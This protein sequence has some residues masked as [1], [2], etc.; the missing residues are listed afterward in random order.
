[1]KE[2]LAVQP[3]TPVSCAVLS[4]PVPIRRSL[5]VNLLAVLVLLAVA[6]VAAMWL[7]ARRTARQLSGAVI[8]QALDRAELELQ[9]FF[10]PVER[11]LVTLRDWAERGV[12]DLRDTDSAERLLTGPLLQV[13]WTTALILAD[14]EGRHLILQFI[15]EHWS[16]IQRGPT[17]GGSAVRALEW[18]DAAP[19]RVPAEVP[20]RDLRVRPWYEAASRKPQAIVWTG[21]YI[22][23]LGPVGLTASTTW[24]GVESGGVVGID[25]TLREVSRFTTS[26]RILDQGVVFVLTEDERAVGLPRNPER[27]RSDGDIESAL[28]KRPEGLGPAAREVAG[29]LLAPTIE[30]DVPYRITSDLGPLWAQVRPFELAGSPLTIG[31]AVPESDILGELQKLRLAVLA[32]LVAV[33]AG[34]AWR[35]RVM[36][37]SFSSPIEQLVGQSARMAT[38]DLEPGEAVSSHIAEV[39]EL[40]A[41]HDKMRTGLKTLLKLEDDLRIAREIQQKTLPEKLPELDGFELEA[42]NEPADETGGD[43]YDLI[44]LRS[45]SAAEKVV[46]TDGA[47]ERALLLLADATGHGIGPALSVTQVR[48]MLRMAAR[49]AGDLAEV[50]R[51]M[52]EQLFADLPPA[53]FITAWLGLLDAG[54]NTLTS[55]S[56]AQA[57]LLHFRAATEECEVLGSDGL[58]LGMFAGI[59]IELP[60][61]IPLAPGDIF[62]VLSDGIFEA[63]G[64]SGDEEFGL[65]RTV[66]VL[67]S[68]HSATATEILTHIREAVDEF[69]AG[70]PA[71]DD[72]TIVLVKRSHAREPE[73]RRKDPAGRLKTPVRPETRNNSRTWRRGGDS[74]P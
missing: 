55:F 57:P 34:A 63:K 73:A 31:V 14:D 61:P 38:G 12:L 32:I 49:L 18:T 60:P 4:T 1:M 11:Q 24:S 10:D 62:A 19:E 52:N 70:A 42:W 7:S 16:L 59:P 3:S 43:S 45:A 47:A 5:V 53:R 58:A 30:R 29:Q 9:A 66:E 41:A 23:N 26:L 50:A 35:A 37:R 67:R 71:D 20:N 64:E 6:I 33:L 54:A 44:G 40:S 39:H 65:E 68:H 72:R 56:A 15:D 22:Y 69:T 25:V 46:L 28:L 21:P 74:N 17:E 2:G 13:A 36:A 51:E 8:E 48:A 27:Y